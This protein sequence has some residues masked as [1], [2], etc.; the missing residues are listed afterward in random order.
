[1]K[2]ALYSRALKQ[3]WHLAWEHKFLWV[4]GLFATFLGQMGI[5]DILI[6]TGK[7]GS[8]FG[9]YPTWLGLPKFFIHTIKNMPMNGE[10]VLWLI[11]LGLIIL[12]ML[13][14]FTF[15]AVVSQGAIIHSAAQFSKSKRKKLPD[16]GESWQ[17]GLNHFWRL[18]F[19]N[20]FKKA[21]II[22][23][24]VLVGW[25]TLS[26]LYTGAGIDILFF[27]II[28]LLAALVGFVLSFWSIYAAG[29]VVVE[30]YGLSKSIKSAWKLFLEHWLVSM[31]VGLV[32]LLLNVL[33]AIAVIIG[34]FVLF[35]PTVLLWFVS[36][37]TANAALYIVGMFVG[38]LLFTAFIVLLGSFFTVYTTSVWTYLFMKMHKSGILSGIV[39]VFKK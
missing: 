32:V 30:E 20:L 35:L 21:I 34:F 18:F 1:M 14:F 23:F 5:L 25:S 4:F 13:I 6:K 17:V 19:I 38:L 11:C 36:V 27:I 31:E 2:K 26:V 16:I 9:I 24:A 12:G 3:G 28:F 33:A 39:A 37:L 10:Q 29:Y 15:L 7:A 22:I 8:S